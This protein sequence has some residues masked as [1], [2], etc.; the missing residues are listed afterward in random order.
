MKLVKNGNGVIVPEDEVPMLELVIT[1]AGIQLKSPLPPSDVCK[2]LSNLSV[3]L[4]FQHF[5]PKEISRI[6]PV[7]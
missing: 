6:E 7:Q 4:M 3:D 5:Q 1:R 2:L